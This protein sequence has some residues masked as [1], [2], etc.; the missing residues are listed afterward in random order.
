MFRKMDY[1][2]CQWGAIH[3]TNVDGFIEYHDNL[4]IILEGKEIGVP[5]IRGQS[6]AFERTVDALC[7]AGK[8]AFVIKFEH[9][10]TDLLIKAGQCRVIKIYGHYNQ[11]ENINKTVFELISELIQEVNKSEECTATPEETN[12]EIDGLEEL[13]NKPKLSAKFSKEILAEKE[14]DK[15]LAR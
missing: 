3:P 11:T 15:Q 1:N 2:D 12:A 14:L 5:E 4:F 7:R 6:V 13:M 9:E 8:K 10:K